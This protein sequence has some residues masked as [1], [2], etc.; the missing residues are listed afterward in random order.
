VYRAEALLD[1]PL[2]QGA[3][4]TEGA[5]AVE[6]VR[7]ALVERD[8]ALRRAREDLE[9]AR[10]LASTW[11][12]EVVAA[13]VQ[14]QRGRVELAEAEGLKT[15]LADKAVALL[16]VE[17][18]LRQDRA[19]R[20]ETD[21]HLQRERAA[22]V[23]A[24]AA[25]EQGRM[26]RE[27]ALGQLQWE[28]AVLEEAQA[29]L[30]K[31]EEISRLN[32]ELVQ[33]SISRED[34][35]QSLEEQEVSYLKLQREAEETRKSL[36]VEKKQVESKLVFVWFLFADSFSVSL[37]FPSEIRSRVD[38][39]CSW[40]PGLRTA[41]GHATTRAETLQTAYNSS[42]QESEELRAAALET[43]QAVEEGEAQ[44]GSSLASRLRALGGHVS[45]RMRHALHLGVQKAL[46]VVGSHYQANF[47][48]V[49]SGYV[50]PVGI[51]DE[52]AMERVDTLAATAAETLAE[53]FVDF[54]FPDAPDAGEPQA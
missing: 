20:R 8:D 42:Q 11:E 24:R 50:V 22:L 9:G 31:Q 12:A 14:L 45:R 44:A 43:C 1:L 51:E 16:A 36:E 48:A 28:R 15:A 35:R 5:S 18:H 27:E 52:V 46:G 25:L 38:L 49:A 17:E 3:Q 7:T 54:L 41:L 26:A 37:S 13:R 30:K 4:A 29:T 19:A 21:G 2:E 32:G 39:P 23:E 40:S 34:Q 53:D 33:I 6:R 10:S 47:E